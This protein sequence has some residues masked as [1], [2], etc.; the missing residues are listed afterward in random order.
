M[1]VGAALGN[2]PSG[3]VFAQETLAVTACFT[4]TGV[5][6]THAQ[7][8]VSWVHVG[9]ILRC[10]RRRACQSTKQQQHLHD[11]STTTGGLEETEVPDVASHN[12]VNL[13]NNHRKVCGMP[14][15]HANP[16]SDQLAAL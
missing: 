13:F 3:V 2:V 10:D 16:M 4:K 12:L 11:C 15:P 1:R 6:S 8:P 14:S 5:G 7:T 9:L